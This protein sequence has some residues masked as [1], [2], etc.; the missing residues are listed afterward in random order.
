MTEKSLRSSHLEREVVYG[1]WGRRWAEACRQMEV[2]GSIEVPTERE[3]RSFIQT[4]RT[5]GFRSSVRKKTGGGYE[6]RKTGVRPKM[7]WVDVWKNGTQV[8]RQVPDPGGEKVP[9]GVTV[10]L[11]ADLYERLQKYCDGEAV[12]RGEAI[13]RIIDRDLLRYE[14]YAGMWQAN[15]LS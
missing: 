5:C 14:R 8:R 6:V 3:M 11:S 1:P 10:T 2:G 4:M 9:V 13:A 12:G 15:R 7:V